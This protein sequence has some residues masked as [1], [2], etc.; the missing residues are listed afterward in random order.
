MIHYFRT[1]IVL[2]L[3]FVAS[4]NDWILSL[5]IDILALMIDFY[6]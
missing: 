2:Q 5:V 1:I 6:Y 3:G 4:T